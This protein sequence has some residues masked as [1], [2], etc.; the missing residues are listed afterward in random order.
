M[1]QRMRIDF[2]S[3]GSCPW[4]VIGLQALEEALRRIGSGIAT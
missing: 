4:R 1:S 2:A 3:E